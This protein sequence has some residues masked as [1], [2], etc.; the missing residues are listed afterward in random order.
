MVSF[1]GIINNQTLISFIAAIVIILIGII[2][3]RVLSRILKKILRE[4]ETDRIIK[5]QTGFNLK[6]QKRVPSITKYLI[7]FIALVTALNQLGITATV[8]FIIILIIAI[9]IIISI[10]LT[11][12]NLIPNIRAGLKIYKNKTIKLEQKIKIRNTE[13]I[14]KEINLT[15][16]R[17]QLKNKETIYVPN[18]LITKP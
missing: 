6:L 2:I 7:Y 16:T 12:K 9:L 5:K 13:G 10:I 4:L 1:Q 15:Q 17:I 3:A 8:I 14:V 11:F 18:S